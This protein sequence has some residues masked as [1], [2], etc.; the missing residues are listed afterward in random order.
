MSWKKPEFKGLDSLASLVEVA[1]E[2]ELKRIR[3]SL[4]NLVRVLE[5]R[6]DIPE[7]AKERLKDALAAADST[8]S[9]G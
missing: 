4:G 2:H 3:T 5:T 1:R 7:E 8:R 6:D 9:S